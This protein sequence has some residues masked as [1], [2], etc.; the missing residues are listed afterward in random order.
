MIKD[1]VL[2]DRDRDERDIWCFDY[3]VNKASQRGYNTYYL[4]GEHTFLV[5]YIGTRAPS[6][7]ISEA[8]TDCS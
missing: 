1:Y 2:D 4:A 7:L 6:E 8:R 5:Y 3:S